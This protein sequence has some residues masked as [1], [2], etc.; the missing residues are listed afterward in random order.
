MSIM[1]HMMSQFRKP[2]GVGGY[3]AGWI[4][5]KRPSNRTRNFWT[6]D[7]LNIEATHRVLEIGFGPG[8]A[9]E[10][11]ASQ[12]TDG[13]VVGIDHSEMMLRQAAAR[14][15][16]K[17][18]SDRLRLTVGTVEQPPRDLGTFDRVFSINVVQFW[19]DP[20]Q[21]FSDLFTRLNPGGVIATTYQPRHRGANAEDADR[22]A[23]SIAAW[24]SATAFEDVRIERLE[25]QPIPVVCVIGSRPVASGLNTGGLS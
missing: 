15:K 24:M 11:V 8:I 13:E 6:V 19:Q 23:N 7:L 1:S 10:R 20:Q 21:V 9:L 5:A 4:M 22:M 18:D 16:K 14:I 12:V 17:I 3:V 25:L 2:R